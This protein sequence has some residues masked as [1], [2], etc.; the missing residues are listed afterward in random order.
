MFARFELSALSRRRSVELVLALLMTVVAIG[1]VASTARARRDK[2]GSVA[3]HASVAER[4]TPAPNAIGYVRRVRLSPRLRDA[5]NVLGDRL[6]KPGKERLILNG[7]LSRASNRNEGQPARLILESSD[8]M[9]LE[10]PG[11]VSIYIH[12]FSSSTDGRSEAEQEEIQSLLFDSADHF[13]FGQSQGFE[14]RFLGERFRLDDG[15]SPNYTGPFYDVYQV[16]DQTVSQNEKRNQVKLFY[17]NSDTL[18]LERV[19]YRGK[20]GEQSPGIEVQI[21]G[22]QR[23]NGQYLPGKIV[24][25]EKGAPVVSFKITSAAI[26]PMADDGIF[27]PR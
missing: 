26:G 19:V 27:R 15:K 6:E 21:T 11:R 18:L 8:K 14:T 20:R 23:V 12:D 3:K 13:F 17:L 1:L 24:R 16:N 7:V 10:E 5:L 2:K 9:R 4:P 22:W 25:L